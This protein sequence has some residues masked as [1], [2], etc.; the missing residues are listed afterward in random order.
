MASE[1]S[2]LVSFKPKTQNL[3][4]VLQYLYSF[5]IFLMLF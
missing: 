3:I 5:N 1:K 2:I 4:Q